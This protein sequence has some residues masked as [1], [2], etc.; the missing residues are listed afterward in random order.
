MLT[1]TMRHRRGQRLDDLWDSLSH[2]WGK[3]TSGRGWKDDQAVFG[4]PIPRLIKSGARKGQ[5]VTESRIGFARVVETTHG[6]D[7]GWH[8]H[9]H[10][11]LFVSGDMSDAGLVTLSESMFGRWVPALVSKGLTAPSLAHGVDVRVVSAGDAAALGDYFSKNVYT[12]EKAGWEVAGGSGKKAARGNRTPFQILADVV[13]VGDADDLAIWWEWEKASHNRRQ[14][15]W[16]AG[17]REL[18]A[19]GDEKSDEEIAE[20][21]LGGDV[22]MML[23]AREYMVIRWHSEQL[24]ELL[25]TSTVARAHAWVGSLVGLLDE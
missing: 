24:L 16:S 4:T 7:N 20:E 23:T 13:A 22:V 17:L 14:L 2:A 10:C 12:A 5:T 11:L 21:E 8:V 15:T 18:L 1:L 6:S 25:E 3:V 19:L 9:I